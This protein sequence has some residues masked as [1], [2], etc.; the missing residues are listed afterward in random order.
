L[1]QLPAR[2]GAR[3]VNRN[4]NSAWAVSDGEGRG[5]CDLISLAS[6]V[7]RC[8]PWDESRNGTHHSSGIADWGGRR[9]PISPGVGAG[10]GNALDRGGGRGG[11]GSRAGPITPGIGSGGGLDRNG[12]GSGSRGGRGG[13]SRPGDTSGGSG[14]ESCNSSDSSGDLHFDGWICS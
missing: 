8:S 2:S 3:G 1:V 9:S 7:E 4:R 13:I 5:R 12:S 11:L 14:G 6:V 10:S